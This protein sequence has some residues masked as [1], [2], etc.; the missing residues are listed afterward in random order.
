MKRANYRIIFALFVVIL[1][2]F[3]INT[4]R[5]SSDSK[6]IIYSNEGNISLKP[7]HKV[8]Y[9]NYPD[10]NDVSFSTNNLNDK[11]TVADFF[12][13]GCP[14]ICPDMMRHM[15]KLALDYKNNSDVQ[16]LSIS[17]DPLNDTKSIIN[18]YIL[19]HQANFNNWYF[20]ESETS[21]IES[22]VTDGFLLSSDNLPGA[23]STKFILI[24]SNAEI[25]GYYDPFLNEMDSNEM[26]KLKSDID[27]LLELL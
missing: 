24:N 2:V 27:T 3:Y 20:L 9:F 25:V 8:S 15:R 16:F 13:T 12:F 5:E 17:V 6:S 21:S 11:V 7:I 22:L 26:D 10:Q 4:T 1:C 19:R 18:S 23:H 14:S